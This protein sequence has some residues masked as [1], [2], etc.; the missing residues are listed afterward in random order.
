MAQKSVNCY[1]TTVV[2]YNIY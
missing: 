1:G 2:K